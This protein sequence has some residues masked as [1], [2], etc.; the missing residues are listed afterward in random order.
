MSNGIH[1]TAPPKKLRPVTH[2]IRHWRVHRDL[3][4]SA[5]AEKAGVGNSFISQLERGYC[6]Y[7]Q[8]SL[9]KLA[10]ALG[11][12]PWQLLAGPPNSGWTRLHDSQRLLEVLPEERHHEAD[13]LLAE[14]AEAALLTAVKIWGPKE[15]SR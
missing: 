4:I 5:L 11:V 3:T 13:A 6:A 8:T 1:R 12:R 9:E 14:M 10:K 15:D 7:T 2:Y